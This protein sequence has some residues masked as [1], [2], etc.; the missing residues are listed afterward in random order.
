MSYDS[1]KWG[2][3]QEK[4]ILGELLVRTDWQVIGGAGVMPAKRADFG[5]VAGTQA[6][7]LRA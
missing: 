4:Y 3:C 1:T 7:F 2:C 6:N 5:F